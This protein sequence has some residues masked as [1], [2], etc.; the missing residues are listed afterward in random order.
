MLDKFFNRSI[1]E[2]VI[3][4]LIASL[5]IGLFTCLINLKGSP[6]S[7]EN[8][9]RTVLMPKPLEEEP[10]PIN[11]DDTKKIVK[12]NTVFQNKHLV[13]KELERE[14]MLLKKKLKKDRAISEED[15]DIWVS[16]SLGE[17]RNNDSLV[18]DFQIFLDKWN[19]NPPQQTKIVKILSHIN[20][21]LGIKK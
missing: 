7:P 14:G 2:Q 11:V 5:I 13:L 16:Q 10:L 4:S 18:N 8:S 9:D 19:D 17:L 6:H 1:K 12:R 3:A 21:E 20:Y 15:L